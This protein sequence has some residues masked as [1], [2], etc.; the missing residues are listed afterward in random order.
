MAKS[1]KI[2]DSYKKGEEVKKNVFA[3]KY[4]CYNLNN[5]EDSREYTHIRTV[6]RKGGNIYITDRP[7]K[8]S[9]GEHTRI[10]VRGK[11]ETE[12]YRKMNDFLKNCEV[13]KRLSNI[14]RDEE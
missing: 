12:K 5:K 4:V 1:E 8:G 14:V 6:K 9:S 7:L 10:L 11:S 2:S 13:R 3:L